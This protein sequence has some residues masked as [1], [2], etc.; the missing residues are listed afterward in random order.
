MDEIANEVELTKP[1]LYLY[2]K[3]KESLYFAVVNRGIKN[4]RFM[5]A[6]EV[7]SA[8]ASGLKE[9]T[10]QTFLTQRGFS[11]IFNITSEDYKKMYFQG[12]NKNRVVDSQKSFIHAVVR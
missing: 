8:Q 3:D 12:I 4:L 11:Q 7:K 2:F 1:T 5:V 6:E 9:E 10:V